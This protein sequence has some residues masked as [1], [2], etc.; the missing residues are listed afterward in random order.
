MKKIKLKRKIYDLPIEVLLTITSA[1][2]YSLAFPSI[3]SDTGYPIFATFA[4]IPLL[5]A[6]NRTRWAY[7]SLLGI[8][9]GLSF[10]TMFNY[11]LTTFHPYSILLV[12]VLRSLQLVLLFPIFKIGYH[13]PKK[14]RVLFQASLY[15]LYMFIVQQGFLGYPYGNLSS[16]FSSWLPL[17]Q[18]SSITG[19]WAIGFV[20]IIPQLFVANYFVKKFKNKRSNI[21]PDKDSFFIFLSDNSMLIIMYSILMLINLVFGFYTIE[22]YNKIEPSSEIKIATIQHNSDTWLGGY[23]QYKKNYISMRDLTIKAMKEEPDMVVWSETAFVPSVE[24]HTNY[25]SSQLT[26]TLVS[27]FVTFGKSLPVPLITGNPEGILKDG[28]TEPFDEEGNWNRDDYNSVILFEEGKLKDTY[29]KQHLVP[30]TEYFPYGNTFPKFNKFLNNNDFHFWLPGHESKIFNHNGLDFST[31]ICFEDIFPDITRNFAKKGSSLLLN[32]SNDS[33]SKS[34]SAEMQHLYLGTYRSIENRRATV[35]S[36][37]S[38]ITCLILPTGE[39]VDPMEP[40]VADYN[41]YNAPVY[42]QEDFGLSFYTKHGDW[43][44]YLIYLLD[45]TYIVYKIL[46]KT[47]AKNKI[48]K[49]RKPISE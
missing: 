10:F 48:I 42:T 25:P 3:I 33:W 35:K 38:G 4:L 32:L 49:N 24:W 47:I 19:Q 17:I 30:F 29:K 20:M 11:W 13:L 43:F 40:F 18:M 23:N 34:V 9:W 21:A 14:N 7:S 12:T 22:W 5:I 26:S 41:I 8:V 1:G 36:T 27:N 44:V 6:I 28:C 16:A 31:S 46:E 39:V 37:N 2:L 45:V 15:P